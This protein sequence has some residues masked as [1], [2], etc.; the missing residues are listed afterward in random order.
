M[1]ENAD[2]LKIAYSVYILI[3]FNANSAYMKNI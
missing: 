1:Y 3:L 2:D